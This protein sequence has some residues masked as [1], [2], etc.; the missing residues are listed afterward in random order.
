MGT[1]KSNHPTMW[2]AYIAVMYPFGRNPDDESIDPA[3]A[4][5]H[6]MMV[7]L[8]RSVPNKTYMYTS[9]LVH[10]GHDD[11]TMHCSFVFFFLIFFFL[12]KRYTHQP[13]PPSSLR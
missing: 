3:A 13:S 9:P 4:E 2:L 7:T 11:L 6:T 1:E 5:Q 8:V 10:V 12:Y